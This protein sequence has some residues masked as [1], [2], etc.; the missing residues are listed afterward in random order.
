M[1]EFYKQQLRL[2]EQRFW[3]LSEHGNRSKI[4]NQ[5]RTAA[6]EQVIKYTALL[7]ALK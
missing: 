4:I 1:K 3:S 5:K 7:S 2:A 6:R